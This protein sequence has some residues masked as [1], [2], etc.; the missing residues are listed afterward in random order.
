MSDS[1]QHSF[2]LVEHEINRGIH[3]IKHQYKL[4]FSKIR[5]DFSEERIPEKGSEQYVFAHWVR[6][7]NNPEVNCVSE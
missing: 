4:P 5:K 6:V 2:S 1:S 7:K 3:T